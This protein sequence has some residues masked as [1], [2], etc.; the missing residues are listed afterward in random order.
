VRLEDDKPEQIIE[1]DTISRSEWVEQLG[2]GE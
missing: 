2:A 1:F